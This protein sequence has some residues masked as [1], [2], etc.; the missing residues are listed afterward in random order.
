MSDKPSEKRGG[1]PV[2]RVKD[3]VRDTVKKDGR[4]KRCR[5]NE[6]TANERGERQDV[7]VGVSRRNHELQNHD[8]KRPRLHNV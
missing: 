8:V 3:R 1:G 2:C 7:D 5:E 4:K 6:H